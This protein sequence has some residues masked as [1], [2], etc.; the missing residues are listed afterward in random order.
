MYSV[1]EPF[2]NKPAVYLLRTYAYLL[3]NHHAYLQTLTYTQN[4]VNH[5]NRAYLH[6]ITTLTPPRTYCVPTCTYACLYTARVSTTFLSRLPTHFPTL[7]LLL[8]IADVRSTADTPISVPN[9]YL[10]VPTVGKPQH[11]PRESRETHLTR[12]LQ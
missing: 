8:P 4:T 7:P 5:E 2:W 1:C 11:M 9:A 10:L 3:P 12:A 6:L